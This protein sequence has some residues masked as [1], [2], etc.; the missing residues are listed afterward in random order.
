MRAKPQSAC[1]KSS[2]A[3]N[4][5]GIVH[6]GDSTAVPTTTSYSYPDNCDDMP[7]ASLVPHLSKKV[8]SST[9][10]ALHN[11]SISKNDQK[12]W[13]WYLNS[14]SLKLDWANPTTL[15]IQ[16]EMTNFGQSEAVFQLERP[17]EWAYTVIETNFPVAHPI[18]LHG[19]DFF[20]LA[21]GKGAY[22]DTVKY[23]YNNPVRRD[24][25]MLP[26][27]GYL[28]LAFQTDNPGAWLMHCHIGWHAEQGFALQYI[29][30]QNE[31]PSV[32]DSD[33]LN[34]NCNAWA[35]YNSAI[36]VTQDDSGI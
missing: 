13:R 25:A 12:L 30:R 26:A 10:N 28:V 4:I 27:A 24:T 14:T 18:H 9:Y 5:K 34:N 21:Q 17:N 29:E 6:Y 7:A 8:G 35:S 32:T 3:D 11:V 2:N 19:H 23:N 1:S 15:Q 33:V 36:S 31:I 20:V 22:N 16:N